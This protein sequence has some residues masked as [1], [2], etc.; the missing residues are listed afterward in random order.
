MAGGIY[1]L[2]DMCSMRVGLS[3]LH[4]RSSPVGSAI[5]PIEGFARFPAYDNI[6][7]ILNIASQHRIHMH[8]QRSE[9]RFGKPAIIPAVSIRCVID[10][11]R[12]INI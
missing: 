6:N 9:Y 8:I 7:K 4:T 3:C 1:H 10:N 2:S 12:K 5:Y 11:L